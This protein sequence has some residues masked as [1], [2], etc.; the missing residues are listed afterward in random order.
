M[1]VCVCIDDNISLNYPLNEK[2]FR[3]NLQGKSKHTFHVQFICFDDNAVYE[4]MWK[5]NVQPDRPHLTA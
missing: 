4:L 3:Q 2:C 1:K 5:N